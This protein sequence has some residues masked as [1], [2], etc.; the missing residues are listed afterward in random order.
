MNASVF[1]ISLLSLFIFAAGHISAKELNI[2]T[3][4][5]YIALSLNLD[6][7]NGYG[8]CLDTFGRGYS[9]LMHT[10]TCKPPSK[11]KNAPRND[12]SN[13]ARFEYDTKTKQ[14]RSYA[15]ENQCMQVLLAT[16]K[17]EFALLE[18]NDH[19]HQKFDY[20]TEDKTIRLDVD[21]NRCVSIDTKTIKAGPWVKR[22]L[23]LTECDKT[24][25]SLKQWDIVAS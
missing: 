13:D 3:Q 25:D 21:Q 15:Y 10:H 12:S 17:T 1:N 23:K 14:I 7:P 22:T 18:C 20:N 9:E 8:F 19:P 4:A 6:E 11:D 16:G 2:P 24:E 5:P